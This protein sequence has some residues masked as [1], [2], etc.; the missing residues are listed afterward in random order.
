MSLGLLGLYCGLY[1]IGCIVLRV[2][3]ATAIVRR[4]VRK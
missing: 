2:P 1:G 3:Q 4:V